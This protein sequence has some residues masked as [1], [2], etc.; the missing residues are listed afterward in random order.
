MVF[1]QGESNGNNEDITLSEAII[2]K[3]IVPEIIFND[4][5]IYDDGLSTCETE[6]NKIK[7]INLSKPINS[8]SDAGIDNDILAETITFYHGL[9]G[10]ETMKTYLTQQ[11]INDSIF[12]AHYKV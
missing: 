7:I 10:L 11:D 12:P 4:Y 5:V 9:Y 8:Y 1:R 2:R 6:V 3:E